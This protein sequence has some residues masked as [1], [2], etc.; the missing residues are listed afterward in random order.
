MSTLNLLVL[1]L[2]VVYLVQ[3]GVPA[4]RSCGHCHRAMSVN[5]PS[6]SFVPQ[7][8]PTGKDAGYSIIGHTMIAL[9]VARQIPHAVSIPTHQDICTQGYPVRIEPHHV[10]FCPPRQFCLS[11]VVHMQV[12]RRPAEG[13]VWS[14]GGPRVPLAAGVLVH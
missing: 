8:P 3:V 2:L 9:M 13:Q 7:G 11:L 14:A 1:S 4:S 10:F 5:I 12:A 6:I